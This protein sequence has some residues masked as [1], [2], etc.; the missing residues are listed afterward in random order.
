M[1]IIIDTTKKEI[2][3][4]ANCA[5][6]MGATS[7]PTKD[8]ERIMSTNLTMKNNCTTVEVKGSSYAMEINEEFMCKV[9]SKLCPIFGICK[10]VYLMCKSLFNEI[11]EEM[12]ETIVINNSDIAEEAVIKE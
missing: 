10:N 2:N 11:E 1:K 4:A 6:T 3:A 12:G 8:V 9:I 5:F 7:D